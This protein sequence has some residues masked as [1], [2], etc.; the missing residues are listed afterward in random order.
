M[1]QDLEATGQGAETAEAEQGTPTPSD[2]LMERIRRLEQENAKLREERRAER[3]E[4]LGV[5]HGLTPTEV[6]LLKMVPADQMEAKAQALAAERASLS[7]APAQPAAEPPPAEH[8]AV[9]SFDTEP[10]PQ[11]PADTSLSWQDEL[12]RRI[13][14]ASSLEEIAR[15]QEEFRLRQL[16]GS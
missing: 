13:S 7:K 14:E 16:A 10:A 4:R 3:A 11:A 6:E 15:I 12:N 1:D 2:D 8:P 9:A 5:A